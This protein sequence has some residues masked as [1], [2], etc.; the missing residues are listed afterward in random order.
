MFIEIEYDPDGRPAWILYRMG[1]YVGA[2]CKT[3]RARWQLNDSDGAVLGIFRT[4]G[5]AIKYA[6]DAAIL[7]VS[8]AQE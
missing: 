2:V 3:G 7:W 1:R 6:E 5:Q 4:R 8:K